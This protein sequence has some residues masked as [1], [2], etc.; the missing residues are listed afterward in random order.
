MVVLLTNEACIKSMIIYFIFLSVSIL[1]FADEQKN[2]ILKF[3]ISREFNEAE[4]NQAI[5]S[6]FEYISDD[7]CL[8][9][10]P[11]KTFYD[12]KADGKNLV[13]ITEKCQKNAPVIRTLDNWNRKYNL[14]LAYIAP[15]GFVVIT[16]SGKFKNSLIARLKAIEPFENIIF[17]ELRIPVAKIR[18]VKGQIPKDLIEYANMLP[19]A[20]AKKELADLHKKYDN[21][22]EEYYVFWSE[23]A[24][25]ASK[26]DP[27][28][29]KITIRIEKKELNDYFP[30]VLGEKVNFKRLM[31]TLAAAM[32][33]QCVVNDNEIVLK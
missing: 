33:F 22:P 14:N 23:L 26:S 4:S 3:S 25:L 11:H 16:R 13:F 19:A 17:N 12:N 5:I 28:K 15:N 29:R 24:R 18:I 30:F 31:E 7:T 2:D 20:E 27:F 9:F 21:Y 1:C 32:K 8:V 10:F 6:L